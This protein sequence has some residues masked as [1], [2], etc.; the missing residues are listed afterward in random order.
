MR[1][2]ARTYRLI[3]I[4]DRCE[5]RYA[6]AWS[7]NKT[8]DHICFSYEVDTALYINWSR[9]GGTTHLDSGWK[10]ITLVGHVTFHPDVARIAFN[11]LHKSSSNAV[12]LF[13]FFLRPRCN[14]VPPPF[15]YHARD[16]N[17][18]KKGNGLDVGESGVSRETPQD[19]LSRCARRKCII[20][21]VHG[22]CKRA[23]RNARLWKIPFRTIHRD[24]NNEHCCESGASWSLLNNWV[25]NMI[26]KDI[27]ISSSRVELQDKI[28]LTHLSPSAI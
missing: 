23:S 14:N 17:Y 28:A 27:F 7:I 26:S 19:N 12:V 21:A 4:F 3:K 15:G 8:V 1:K 20:R 18:Q 25:I 9:K 16:G 22:L 6:S 2:Y 13:F 5:I 24:A 11:K 10:T